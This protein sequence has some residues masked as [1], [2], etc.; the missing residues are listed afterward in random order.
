MEKCVRADLTE[1]ALYRAQMVNL[2]CPSVGPASSNH[3]WL[4][5]LPFQQLFASD[6][7]H[8]C[9]RLLEDSASEDLHK[10]LVQVRQLLIACYKKNICIVIPETHYCSV[11]CVEIGG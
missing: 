6:I 7:N 11:L 1:I 3:S 5:E 2:E 10:V 8:L 9:F 4:R